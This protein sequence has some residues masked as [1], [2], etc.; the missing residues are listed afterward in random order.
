MGFGVFSRLFFKEGVG[1]GVFSRLFF[2]ALGV[3]QVSFRVLAFLPVCGFFGAVFTA[4]F[5]GGT[6]FCVKRSPKTCSFKDLSERRGGGKVDGRVR[7][8]RLQGPRVREELI[9]SFTS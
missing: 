9:C 2:Q 4:H 5:F 3:W 7:D 1:F 8:L 6:D